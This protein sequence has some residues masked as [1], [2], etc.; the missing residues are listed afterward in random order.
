MKLL[1]WRPS[2]RLT[3]HA[4]LKH[5]WFAL[6]KVDHVELDSKTQSSILDNLKKVHKH[7]AIKQ[8]ALSF[9]ASHLM[10]KKEKDEL[11]LM[12]KILDKNGDG[13]LSK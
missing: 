6:N 7:N 10:T 13:K 12:F 8:A 1:K 5:P 11:T 9:L 3:A 4:A 2:E